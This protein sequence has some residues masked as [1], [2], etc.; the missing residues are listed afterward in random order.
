MRPGLNTVKTPTKAKGGK[1]R[2]SPTT[3]MGSNR[4]STFLTPAMKRLKPCSS[5][6]S[7]KYDDDDD[8]DEDDEDYEGNESDEYSPPKRRATRKRVASVGT[9]SKGKLRK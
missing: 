8:D 3:T 7:A 2:G 4:G 1:A 6:R 9:P 5:K